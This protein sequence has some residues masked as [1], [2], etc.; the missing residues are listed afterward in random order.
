MNKRRHLQAKLKEGVENRDRDS[1]SHNKRL[2][3]LDKTNADLLLSNGNLE[4]LLKE[5]GDEA[6]SWQEK[7]NANEQKLKEV[8]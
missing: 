1:D 5:R 7:Y 8:R 6:R 2:S 3:L 4:Q